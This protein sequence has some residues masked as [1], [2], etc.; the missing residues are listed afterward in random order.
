[1]GS[2]EPSAALRMGG[3]DL[4]PPGRGG[5]RR[6]QR[7]CRDGLGGPSPSSLWGRSPSQCAHFSARGSSARPSLPSMSGAGRRGVRP[8]PGD[9]G[10]KDV[11]R[12]LAATNAQKRMN[13][14]KKEGRKRRFC[15]G[16]SFVLL[17]LAGRRQ[18]RG[19]KRRVSRS[20]LP[21]CPHLHVPQARRRHFMGAQQQRTRGRRKTHTSPG[22][23]GD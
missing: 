9:D 1:M 21:L 3:R 8:G 11:T 14:L 10:G 12:G 5:G 20:D 22:A 19:K 15:R 2:A 6:Q 7:H 23:G 18:L 13:A 16:G 17:V 4:C